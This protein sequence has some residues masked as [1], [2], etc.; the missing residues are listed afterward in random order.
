MSTITTNHLRL[1]YGERVIAEDLTIAF[2]KPEIVS[3]IGPN[4]SR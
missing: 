2:D 3:I 1:Q 4:G